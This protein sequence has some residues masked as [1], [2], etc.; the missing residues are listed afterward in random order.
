MRKFKNKSF[1]DNTGA[2]RW[3]PD[4]CNC[5]I[6]YDEN[7]NYL[8]DENKCNLH[9]NLSSQTLVN[10]IQIHNKSFNMKFGNAPTQKQ[11]EQIMQNKENEKVRI[12]KL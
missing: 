4:A 11:T 12:R 9:K 10:A 1:D 2:T 6:I 8:D 7:L 5:I 3:N